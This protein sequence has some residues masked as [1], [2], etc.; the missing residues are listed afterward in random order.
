M[1]M[2]LL[3]KCCT[4]ALDKSKARVDVATTGADGKRGGSSRGGKQSKGRRRKQRNADG[5]QSVVNEVSSTEKDYTRGNKFYEGLHF[6]GIASNRR[7]LMR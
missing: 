7:W 6:E 5:S 2:L 1:L 3:H 4:S